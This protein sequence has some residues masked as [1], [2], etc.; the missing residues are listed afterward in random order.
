MQLKRR[1]KLTS[2]G[3]YIKK[4]LLSVVVRVLQFNKQI[5]YKHE[6]KK[7][8]FIYEEIHCYKMKN[9]LESMIILKKILLAWEK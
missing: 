4:T 2:L 1:K 5:R 7:I 9:K 6:I 8:A 3:H